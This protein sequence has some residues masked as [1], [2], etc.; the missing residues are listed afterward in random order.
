MAYCLP[1]QKAEVFKQALVDGTLDP[2]KLSDM[3]SE[4]RRAAFESVLGKD[5]AQD[6][7][8]EFEKKLLLKNQ[9]AGFITWAKQLAGISEPARTDLISKIERMGNVLDGDSKEAFLA[10]LAAQKLGTGVSFEEAKNISQLSKQVTEAKANW[11]EEKFNKDAKA[12]PRDPNAGWTSETDR[13]DY[14]A[15]RVA[16]QNYIKELKGGE[17]KSFVDR[18]KDSVEQHGVLTGGARSLGDFISTVGGIAKSVKASFDDSFLA[19]Q[20]FKTMFTHPTLWADNAARSFGL[21]ARQ[22]GKDV[23]NEDVLNAVKADILSRPNAMRG[24]YDKAKLDIGNTEEAFPTS[25]VEKVPLLGRMFKASEVAFEGTAYRL[26]ADIFDQYAR[27]AEKGGIDANDKYQARSLGVLVNSLTGRGDLGAFEKVG[28]QVNNIFFSP[29]FM[30]SNFDFLSAHLA[31]DMSSFAKKQAAIN[32][33]KVVIGTALIFGMAK[34]V[35]PNGVEL[36]P[37]SADFGKL[38]FGDTRIDVTGGMGSIVTLAARVLPLLGSFVDPDVKGYTKST[39]SG[40]LVQINSGKFGAEN[41]LDVINDWIDNRTSPVLSVFEDL[42]KGEDS[43]FQTPTPVG[44]LKNF[45]EPFV[46]QNIEQSLADPKSANWLLGE[47]ADGLGF[48]ENTY[49]KPAKKKKQP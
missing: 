49:G 6:V 27:I 25:A 4:E 31:D 37:R 29:K 48:S 28:K 12:N 30:K 45:A 35:D 18:A 8:T 16:I 20:G 15:K 23:S 32:L 14:G 36:D 43:N 13:L 26:R 17:G 34:A 19:R 41:G 46:A 24:L 40:K 22:L 3:T 21:I 5:E 1:F 7:N 44:E 10:D 47:L 11:S 39:T 2:E 38:K 9:Q 33:G 42:F